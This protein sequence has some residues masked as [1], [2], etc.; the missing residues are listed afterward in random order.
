METK[1]ADLERKI[2]DLKKRLPAHSAKPGMIQE[3]EEMEEELRRIKS[4]REAPANDT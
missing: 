3:L 2:S 4:A 1:I